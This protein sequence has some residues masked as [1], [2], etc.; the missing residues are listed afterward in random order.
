MAMFTA[1]GVCNSSFGSPFSRGGSGC[2]LEH[3]GI[4]RLNWQ[5]RELQLANPSPVLVVPAQQSIWGEE[6]ALH[7]SRDRGTIDDRR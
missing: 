5:R 4:P 3:A 6:N 7:F 2:V 1:T